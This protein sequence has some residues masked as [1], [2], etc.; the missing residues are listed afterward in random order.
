MQIE[1]PKSSFSPGMILLAVIIA[2]AILSLPFIAKSGSTK[3][4]RA[5]K[6]SLEDSFPA[7]IREEPAQVSSQEESPIPEVVSLPEEDAL[8]EIEKVI[9]S[10]APIPAVSNLAEPEVKPTKQIEPAQ[11]VVE[12]GLKEPSALLTSFYGDV[13]VVGPNGSQQAEKNRQ[14]LK[15]ETIEVGT[16]GE[17]VLQIEELYV[18]RLK[19]NT[20]LTQLEPK[21]DE[22]FSGKERITYRFK[23][24]Q[25]SLLGTT[26]YRGDKVDN[27]N[28]LIKDRV[29]DVQDS[30]FRVQLSDASPWIGV[31]RGSMKSGTENVLSQKPLVIHA[32]EKEPLDAKVEAPVKVSEQ[33]WGLLR[34]TYEMNVKTAAEEALQQDLSK[35]AGDFFE[36]VF[37]HGNFY[38]ENVGYT[39]RDFYEDK[40][41]G[42][43]YLEAEYD[44]FPSNSFV[45][46]YVL[47]RDLDTRN[48]GGLRFDVRRKPDEGY[49]ERFYLEL[50]SKGQ[51]IHRFEITDIKPQWQAREIEFFTP[52]STPITEVTFVFL[53]DSIGQSKKGFIQMRNIQMIPLTGAQ[54]AAKTEFD[55]N[56]QTGKRPKTFSSAAASLKQ[57]TVTLPMQKAKKAVVGDSSSPVAYRVDAGNKIAE[58]VPKVVSFDDL[59]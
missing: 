55:K 7:P 56:P 8:P 31:L 35:R 10:T 47:T 58:E 30:T 4:V 59:S 15:G 12:L 38:T 29:F 17:A 3:S 42:D 13:K 21:R 1:K 57:A 43:V 22:A 28:L 32:L 36:Y 27:L 51:I 16:S 19:A 46:L 44:V 26:K 48:Y 45:G 52:A 39:V 24:D 40:I 49:P 41:S 54:K 50:K 2:L 23:L 11:Q 25:G 18:L 53:N 5:E 14:I 37:D 33:E 20:K 9:P 34:E 6:E